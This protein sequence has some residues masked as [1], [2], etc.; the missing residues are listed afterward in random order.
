MG[1][2]ARRW[3]VYRLLMVGVCTAVMWTSTQVFCEGH[4]EQGSDPTAQRCVSWRALRVRSP[5]RSDRYD[6]IPEL[7]S[8]RDDRSLN[9]LKEWDE[10]S[11]SPIEGGVHL[12]LRSLLDLTEGEAQRLYL[13]GR[14]SPCLDQNDAHDHVIEGLRPELGDPL[15]LT[16]QSTHPL[17]LWVDGR[18]IQIERASAM[19]WSAQLSSS[20]RDVL[21]RLSPLAGRPSLTLSSTDW[22]VTHQPSSLE[23]ESSAQVSRAQQLDGQLGVKWSVEVKPFG[24]RVVSFEGQVSSAERPASLDPLRDEA[25]VR[26]H[27]ARACEV[28]SVT[29]AGWVT[30]GTREGQA[31][32]WRYKLQWRCA[33]QGDRALL[34]AER[35]RRPPRGARWTLDRGQKSDLLTWIERDHSIGWRLTSG[36]RGEALQRAS[37]ILT[38]QRGQSDSSAEGELSAQNLIRQRAL[39]YA[40]THEQTRDTPIPHAPQTLTRRWGEA[41]LPSV[42]M[43]QLTP[44]EGALWAHF[45]YELSPVARRAQPVF[46]EAPSPLSVALTQR[47][48][49]RSWCTQQE[50]ASPEQSPE[51][52][53]WGWEPE[54]PLPYLGLRCAQHDL[55]LAPMNRP[56]FP[57]L[58]PIPEGA[59]CVDLM[60]PEPT[61]ERCA[62]AKASAVELVITWSTYGETWRAQWRHRPAEHPPPIW[63]ASKRDVVDER[64]P[65]APELAPAD[66]L[67]ETLRPTMG[68]LSTTGHLA[69]WS[70]PVAL[71]AEE[72][73]RLW[74][75]AL[76]PD[77]VRV[78]GSLDT[79]T[80]SPLS[81]TARI[82]LLKEGEDGKAQLR[83]PLLRG[84][85]TRI[86]ELPD[87][88]PALPRLLRIKAGLVTRAYASYRRPQLMRRPEAEGGGWRLETRLSIAQGAS[89]LSEREQLSFAHAVQREERALWSALAR[90]S[91]DTDAE[92]RDVLE[93]WGP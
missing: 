23:R 91:V 68:E 43:S 47:S 61:L 90:P 6:P 5:W 82:Q 8:L 92:V 48:R 27:L 34:V 80:L 40:R 1:L 13:L 79:V 18:G 58:R 52:I 93:D 88:H 53:A 17:A 69:W 84:D 62:S 3:Y 19:T 28:L 66:L 71:S 57:P 2:G 39:L 41:P 21:I 12:R 35:W 14:V 25:R 55:S 20:S 76:S 33:L 78:Q 29:H 26:R 74:R 60:R 63:F 72:R 75:G 36:G 50:G 16:L 38:E 65:Q 56:G 85:Y 15:R 24:I 81:P 11:L 10:L 54:L 83:G 67:W 70:L 64:V 46:N 49:L 42:L 30:Q 59:W 9:E 51:L 87:T 89:V 77:A 32:E 44:S 4:H 86:I 7:L 31:S 37:S 45:S 73:A 22:P